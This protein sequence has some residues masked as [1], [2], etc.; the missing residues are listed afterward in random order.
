MMSEAKYRAYYKPYKCAVWEGWVAHMWTQDTYFQRDF[1]YK[2]KQEAEEAVEKFLV[3]CREK[4]G[5]TES[6]EVK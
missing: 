2:T 3:K 5:Q 6:E 1:S 4:Y